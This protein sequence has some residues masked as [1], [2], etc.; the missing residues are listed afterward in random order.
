MNTQNPIPGKWLPKGGVPWWIEDLT[1]AV[2]PEYVI[3]NSPN[4]I[5]NSS[6]LNYFQTDQYHVC[7]TYDYFSLFYLKKKKVYIL[8]RAERSEKRESAEVYLDFLKD[9]PLMEIKKRDGQDIK[10]EE[11]V[12]QE[13]RERSPGTVPQHPGNF[14]AH[15]PQEGLFSQGIS[16]NVCPACAK[17]DKWYPLQGFD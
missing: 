4:L 10:G 7:K 3:S 9:L 12:I 5:S 8:K 2:D 17:R 1:L 14:P 11:V 13:I 15:S 6:N 16:G